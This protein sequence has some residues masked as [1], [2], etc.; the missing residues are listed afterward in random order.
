MGAVDS[1]GGCACEGQ[2]AIR[3]TLLSALSAQ[4]SCEPKTALKLKPIFLNGICSNMRKPCWQEQ[5][6]FSQ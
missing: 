3:D 5:V 2:G 4:F 1:G 6:D